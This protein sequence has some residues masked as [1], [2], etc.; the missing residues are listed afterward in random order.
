M[1]HPDP[2]V[3]HP[4]D[5]D[6]S[7]QASVVTPSGD[8]SADILRADVHRLGELVGGV[9]REQQGDRIF[10][11]VEYLR[12]SAIA[13]RGARRLGVITAP[14]RHDPLLDWVAQQSS[15]DLLAVIR[16]FGIYFHVI[17]LAEQHHRMR[18]LRVY[19]HSDQLVHES[20]AAA[21]ATLAARGVPAERARTLLAGLNVHP[22]LTA[23][24]SE[25]RRRSLLLQLEQV[26]T[27]LDQLDDPRATPNDRQL[28]LDALRLHIVEIYQSAET[29]MERPSVE[30]E[31]QTAQY[32]VATT[33]YDVAPRLR[34]TLEQAFG[35]SYPE[36]APLD[37]VT[38]LH[39]GSWVGGDR[40]GNPAV[41]GEVTRDVARLAREAILRR[42]RDEVQVLGR[43]LSISLRLVGAS[44]ELLDSIQRD[45]MEL[46]MQPVL[47]WRD[48]PY[49]QKLGL[50]GE[51]LRRAELGGRG[52]YA[53][54]D[55]FAADL[56]VVAASL[57]AHQGGRIADGPVRMLQDR[58][59]TFGFSLAELEIRQHAERHAQ[60]V[61]EVLRHTGQ[62]TY[63]AL[64]EAGRQEML[65]ALLSGPPLMRDVRAYSAA[66]RDT[67]DTFIAIAEIQRTF[68]HD[69]CHTYIISMCRTPSDVLAVLLLARECGLF[70]W[71]RD[72]S[73][74]CDLD[75]V[76]LFETLDELASCDTILHQLMAI[77]AYKGV[78][79][80]R[81][82][83]QQI[84]IGYSDST[85][86]GGYLA[87]S[88]ATYRAAALL[89]RVAQEL[90]FTLVLFHGRGGAIGRGGGPMGRAIR[91]R[92]TEAR[93]PQLKVTEQGEMIFA[94]YGLPDI[95]ERH[96]EQML[97]AL[98]VSAAEEDDQGPEALW[99]EAIIRM[100]TGSRQAYD[101]LVRAAPVTMDFFRQATPFAELSTLQ[102]ASRPVSRSGGTDRV[103][104][105]DI[106]AIPW[107]FSWTQIRAN[108]PGWYGLGTALQAEIASGRLALLRAMYRG[109]RFFALA[110]DN[111]QISL[112]TADM[113][114]LRR[115]ATL[116]AGDE[117]VVR[118]LTEEYERSVTAVLA[119]L[120]QQELLDNMSTLQRTI[121]LRNPYVDALHLAQIT[122]LRRYRSLPPDAPE[123]KR[124]FLLDAIHHSINGIAAG[125]QT[126]G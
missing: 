62:D 105:D 116:A 124:A 50:I 6:M 72:D 94:R 119:V 71:Y 79:A 57:R 15:E 31:A 115:Y 65:S 55:E 110:L 20:I 69:A 114:T 44:T 24:P 99:D 40:D 68:G 17:N 102:L 18:M 54:S 46:D 12:T 29:R 13:A 42:Y 82:N 106:R 123:R 95:A 76:P 117:D 47:Q 23:H 21:L 48:E 9:L 39:I 1:T 37:A 122:L 101:A 28:T 52:G 56:A 60:A 61:A 108:L 22:V 78:V 90:G 64:D 120:G 27:L 53:N 45:R 125:L 113:E 66:T 92:A 35:A 58:L 85:K 5:D 97:S 26:V 32:Y 2:T 111:A 19:A 104:L 75:I 41:S 11:A 38:P 7:R 89:A 112:G 10:A 49:R 93:T 16:A 88:W 126:T 73:A 14:A 83:R 63:L 84:M 96:L 91:A 86:E 100:V 70:A 8:A 109:W 59:N 87:A 121:K 107:V 67:L 34:R 98:L 81:Q 43:D 77:P 25:A 4:Q 36:K 80:A 30:E 33:L 3:G 51:R 74:R 118:A 103:V